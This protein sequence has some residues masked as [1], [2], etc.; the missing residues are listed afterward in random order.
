MPSIFHVIPSLGQ[1]GAEQ[2]LSRLLSATRTWDH[3]VA[4]LTGPGPGDDPL[5]TKL[6]AGGIPVQNLDCPRSLP[7]PMATRRLFTLCRAVRPAI[8]MGWMYH[9]CLAA[10]AL[11]TFCERRAALIWTIRSGCSPHIR[12]GTRLV[13]SM[14]RM[15]SHRP[16]AIVYPS[17]R[18]LDQH[19]AIGFSA[20]RNQLIPNGYDEHLDAPPS[21]ARIT[22]RKELGIA[23]STP[24]I[25]WIG[26]WHRDKA[27]ENALSAFAMVLQRIPSAVMIMAGTGCDVV[28]PGPVSALQGNQAN[29]AVRFLGRRDD[30]SSLMAASD[31][32][33]LSSHSESFP[34]V[35]AESM[36]AGTPCVSTD[37]GDARTIVGSTGVVVDAGVPRQLADSLI[38]ILTESA[39]CSSNRRQSAHARIV[40]HFSMVRVA[41]SY[42]ALWQTALERKRI[43]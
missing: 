23:E 1:G 29:G 5:A 7:S 40:G 13:R 37:V 19:R 22:I 33:C 20:Q 16:A 17:H 3:R 39:N 11:E 38:M 15:S 12:P 30:A 28:D 35:L 34:N 21:G 24:L 18:A 26:R 4:V 25:A 14:L 32:L 36:L 43:G 6:R 42:D 8:I 10:T 27:P 9:G 31:V 2:A 41:T